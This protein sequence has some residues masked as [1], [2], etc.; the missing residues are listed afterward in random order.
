MLFNSRDITRC[1]AGIGNDSGW[2][3]GR[4]TMGER[5]LTRRRYLLAAGA[6]GVAGLAGCGSGGGSE[7][8]DG[9][10]GS[11]QDGDDGSGSGDDNGGD[12]GGSG[13]EDGSGD[14]ETPTEESEPIEAWPTFQHD[15]ARTGYVASGS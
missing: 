9:D 8:G 4:G 5:N 1:G 15:A 6:S 12:G 3:A 13:E 2:S 10:A 14:E 7:S 11:G